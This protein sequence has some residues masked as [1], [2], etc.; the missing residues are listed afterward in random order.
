MAAEVDFKFETF[1]EYFGDA[2]QVKRLCEDCEVCGSKLI[3]THMSDYKNLY[4]QETARCPDCGSGGG[5][6][7]HILN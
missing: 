7:I 4:V 3:H 1:E 6:K 2:D 5:K